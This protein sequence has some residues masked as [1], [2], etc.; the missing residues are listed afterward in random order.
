MSEM[1][2]L[3]KILERALELPDEARAALAAELLGSLEEDVDEDAEAQWS[4]EIASRL[5]ELDSGAVKA[6]PWSEARPAILGVAEDEP[7][8]S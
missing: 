5:R 1:A 2:D 7:A 6:V 4:Q 3:K 8:H